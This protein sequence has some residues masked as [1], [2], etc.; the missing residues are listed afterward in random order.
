MAQK[1]GQLELRFGELPANALLDPGAVQRAVGNLIDNALT[2]SGSTQLELAASF[3][4]ANLVLDVADE[5]C[6]VPAQS[7]EALFDAFAQGESLNPAA[8]GTGLG[9]AIVRELARAHGGN[10]RFVD[11]EVGARIRFTIPMTAEDT[12]A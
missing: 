6:G 1:G 8:G 11:S 3:D 10:A 7:Q 5:G 12:G 2:H 9:L 4:G